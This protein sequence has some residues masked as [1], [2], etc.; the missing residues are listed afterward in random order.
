MTAI[1]LTPYTVKNGHGND[2]TYCFDKE[3]RQESK[4]FLFLYPHLC[5]S[6]LGIICHS[7]W[8]EE[9]ESRHQWIADL[10][11]RISSQVWADF[12]TGGK[13]QILQ[14]ERLHFWLRDRGGGERDWEL[15]RCSCLDCLGKTEV[16][17]WGLTGRGLTA[18]VETQAASLGHTAQW[19]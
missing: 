15:G 9:T 16:D 11:R 17:T 19:E 5:H 8:L 1:S 18:V 10:H 6:R 4:V 13:Y 3:D 2:K 7:P 12:V 14:I